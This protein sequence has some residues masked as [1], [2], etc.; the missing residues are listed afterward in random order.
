VSGVNGGV[1][2][3]P[4]QINTRRVDYKNLE[5]K[6]DIFQEGV[7]EGVIQTFIKDNKISIEFSLTNIHN[8]DLIKKVYEQYF[9]T[10]FS[11]A[12]NDYKAVK[13]VIGFLMTK[14]WMNTYIYELI[15]FE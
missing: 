2:S 8:D 9:I 3:V 7:T 10:K 5:L 11:R 6:F 1:G 4:N 15:Y 13:G 12:F 14:L